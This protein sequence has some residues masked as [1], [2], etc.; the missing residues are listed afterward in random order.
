V[1][2]DKLIWTADAYIRP[3]TYKAAS[4]RIIGAHHGL[5]IASAW[6]DGTTSSSDRQFFRSAKRGDAAGEVSARFGHD[7]GLGFYTHV[8]DQHGTYSVR[9]MSATSHEAPYVLDGLMHHGTSLRIGT[10]YTDTA[11]ASF[12]YRCMKVSRQCRGQGGPTR[13]PVSDKAAAGPEDRCRGGADDGDRAGDE[14]GGSECRPRW[15]SVEPTVDL[16]M[17]EALPPRCCPVTVRVGD[18]PSA[19][20]GRGAIDGVATSATGM[21]DSA[22][23]T[24]SRTSILAL[25]REAGEEASH[26]DAATSSALSNYYPSN[27]RW[28]LRPPAGP[29][30]PICVSCRLPKPIHL[31][32]ALV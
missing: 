11:R 21:S 5:P 13:Q 29:C 10:H 26:G 8:S 19:D 25:L 27:Q 6:G 3:E 2:R 23:R 12:G 24:R 31:H 17:V 22:W 18:S 7:P 9:V 28:R 30:L 1:T 32:L 4:A 16:I 15:I 20:S 14:R